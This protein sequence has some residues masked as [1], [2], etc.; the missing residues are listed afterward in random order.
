MKAKRSQLNIPVT[1]RCHDQKSA[2]TQGG[3]EEEDDGGGGCRRSPEVGALRPGSQRSEGVESAQDPQGGDERGSAIEAAVLREDGVG[4][5]GPGD[6]AKVH[7][8]RGKRHEACR[9]QAEREALCWGVQWDFLPR[10]CSL[11]R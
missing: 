8:R 7:G 10:A 5:P 2:A 11:A 9:Q 1:I 3:E 6:K 4:A